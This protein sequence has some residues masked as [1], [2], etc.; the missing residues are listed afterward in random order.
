[1]NQDFSIVGAEFV[2]VGQATWE[3]GLNSLKSGNMSVLLPDHRVLITKTGRSL[4]GLNL[5]AI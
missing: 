1:M 3:L 2:S 4:K 5:E